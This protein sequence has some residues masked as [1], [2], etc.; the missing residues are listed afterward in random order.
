VERHEF[1]DVASQEY[2]KELKSFGCSYTRPTLLQLSEKNSMT[3]IVHFIHSY[4][5]C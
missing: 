1:A 4:H 2:C 3:I 5:V